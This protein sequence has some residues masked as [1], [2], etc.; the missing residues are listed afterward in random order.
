MMRVGFRDLV[1]Q[2]DEE[3]MNQTTESIN[4]NYKIVIE[5]LNDFGKLIK[6]PRVI[7]EYE[8]LTSVLTNEFLAYKDKVIQLATANRNDE[9]YELVFTD[10]VEINSKIS[11]AISELTSLKIELAATVSEDNT[12][13]ANTSILLMYIIIIIGVIASVVLGIFLSS[14]IGKPIRKLAKTANKIALGD[15]NVSVEA[16]TRDEI[17]DL[18][19]SFCN[20]IENIRSQALTTEKIAA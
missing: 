14:I 12:A 1:I 17:G 5:T 2:L 10:G 4:E 20:M 16:T 15:V 13:T 11:D 18:M 7:S 6:D 8:N 19:A 9:A 3:T